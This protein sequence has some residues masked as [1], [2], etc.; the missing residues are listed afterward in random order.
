MSASDLISVSMLKEKAK[1]WS[2]CHLALRNTCRLTATGGKLAT[3]AASAQVD[4]Q[5]R[6]P[7]C[8]YPEEGSLFKNKHTHS[9]D[10]FSVSVL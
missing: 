8:V 3:M 6:N 4:V 7:T 10:T 1:P 2:E 5:L 9:I